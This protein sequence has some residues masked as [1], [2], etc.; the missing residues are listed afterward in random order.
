MFRGALAQQ[1]NDFEL[2]LESIVE[3]QA[4]A[5]TPGVDVRLAKNGSILEWPMFTSQRQKRGFSFIVPSPTMIRARFSEGYTLI[6]EGAERHLPVP[7]K[8]A[9][10][11]SSVFG[12]SSQVNL[13]VTPPNNS[14]FSF[15][16]DNHDV[17][18][19][20]LF[21][22]KRWLIGDL[23]PADARPT[24]VHSA[25]VEEPPE[26]AQVDL[27]AGD[28]LY[29]PRGTVHAATNQSDGIVAH[30]TLGLHWPVLGDAIQAGVR[31]L[32]NA[33]YFRQHWTPR[34]NEAIDLPLEALHSAMAED[35]ASS[36]LRWVPHP[37]GPLRMPQP[38][39][40]T[41]LSLATPVC[42]LA[43]SHASSELWVSGVPLA[44]PPT[45][46]SEILTMLHE[47]TT[48]GLRHGDTRGIATS[49]LDD[50]LEIGAVVAHS[51]KGQDD[52]QWHQEAIKVG[53]TA[54]EATPQP[55]YD[56]SER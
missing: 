13:Y 32:V 52:S 49:V 46:H 34:T 36:V 40:T 54:A 45:A 3:S 25:A 16:A 56:S 55:S 39:G 42:G 6:V 12:C 30:A 26:C 8:L 7:Q 10:S 51:T 43:S 38:G 22:T 9:F 28:V 37:I 24:R 15:H 53:L 29:L 50:L 27:V 1:T 2:L 17:L 44:L 14:G 19:V 47:L 18:A 48:S 5:G 33:G 21:G 23:L 4:W 41:S 31:R 11:A 35:E 20:Q